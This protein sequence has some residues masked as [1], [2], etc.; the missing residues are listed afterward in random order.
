MKLKADYL[1]GT[2]NELKEDEGIETLKKDFKI[3]SCD[4]E[5]YFLIPKGTELDLECDMAGNYLKYKDVEI[6]LYNIGFNATKGTQKFDWALGFCL[7][8]G[9]SFRVEG[10]ELETD[11]DFE[12]DKLLK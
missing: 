12:A 4:D 9:I 1:Y 8:C 7:D 2:V 10:N 3:V 11:F 5:K 6:G